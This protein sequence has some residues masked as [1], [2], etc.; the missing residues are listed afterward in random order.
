MILSNGFLQCQPILSQFPQGI[1]K[2]QNKLLPKG[3]VTP[4]LAMWPSQLPPVHP[5]PCP[6]SLLIC[7]NPQPYSLAGKLPLLC[8]G[9]G[10]A[11]SGSTS[12]THP[13][14]AL[15]HQSNFREILLVLWKGLSLD[16]L[17]CFWGNFS[18]KA[19]IPSSL[20]PPKGPISLSRITPFT[21]I[22]SN[23]SCH[24]YLHANILSWG[25]ESVVDLSKDGQVTLTIIIAIA[26]I[27]LQV[28]CLTPEQMLN[29]YK[30]Y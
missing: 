13:L 22:Q 12:P 15:F 7:L 1:L 2:I 18:Y 3:P 5:A 8:R 11:T 16:Q 19:S 27:K 25:P 24:C 30:L 29:E 6:F 17:L 14:Y 26:F 23:H 4:Y 28:Q 9:R 10:S 20:L 21:I